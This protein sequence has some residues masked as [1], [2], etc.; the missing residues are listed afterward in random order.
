M[1]DDGNFSPDCNE[2]P[3]LKK[4]DCNGK[5]EIA[6]EKYR[7]VLFEGRFLLRRNDKS[8]DVMINCCERLLRCFRTTFSDLQSVARHKKTTSVEVVYMLR[9]SRLD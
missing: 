6:P 3:F 8:A 5:R 4:K 1:I 9:K 7:D 2:N